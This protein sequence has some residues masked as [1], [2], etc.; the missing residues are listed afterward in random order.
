MRFTSAFKDSDL[1]RFAHETD[2]RS[3]A[4]VARQQSEREQGMQLLRAAPNPRDRSLSSLAAAWRDRFPSAQRPTALCERYPRVANRL[5]L[6]WDDPLLTTL[7]F[8]D[9]FD[10]YRG[11]R[12]RR[13]FPPD[14]LRELRV[15]SERV[16]RNA[17]QNA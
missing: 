10:D 9:L 5:A 11:S 8:K 17:T 3:G 12:V 15:L 6:C 14:V 1:V 4:D 2:R 13:G 16:G 7:L